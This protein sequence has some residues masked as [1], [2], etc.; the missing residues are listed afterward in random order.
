[1]D[2]QFY[3][4]GGCGIAIT[5][6]PFQESA[7]LAA[8]RTERCRT[9][10]I[11]LELRTAT[12]HLILPEGLHWD[13]FGAARCQDENSL[14]TCFFRSEKDETVACRLQERD[15]GEL[16]A[17]LSPEL[18]KHPGTNLVMR[19]LDLPRMLLPQGAIFL[20]AS[21]I[22]YRGKAILFTAPKQTGKS[23]QARLWAQYRGAEQI[24]GDRAL[25]RQVDGQ[26]MAFGS[27]FCG[28]STI[29]KN[30][31]LPIAAIVSLH[32]APFNRVTEAN[33]KER[34]LTFL[35]GVTYDPAD[36]QA[37]E[38]VVRIGEEIAAAV[39]ILR[40]DCL[41]DEDAVRTLCA[42]LRKISLEHCD[43]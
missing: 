22:D 7:H 36:K 34:L 40:L 39:P 24:N 13:V 17:E 14:S 35:Q 29:C 26:W 32:Q 31:T 1:M 37:L 18:V 43:A 12:E 6:L 15:E 25:L 42:Y 27:P 23:T 2:A 10:E 16:L 41:P 8:F 28:S 33:P 9:P 19:C 5:G 3:E 21:Y 38:T 11:R 4:I 30:R 20:H